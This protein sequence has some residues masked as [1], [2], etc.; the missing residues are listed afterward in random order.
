MGIIFNKQP[1]MGIKGQCNYEYKRG[2]RLYRTDTKR[3]LGGIWDS[4]RDGQAMGV[5]RE[6]SGAIFGQTDLYAASV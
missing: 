6:Y 4:D 5:W 3:F 2:K 1:N